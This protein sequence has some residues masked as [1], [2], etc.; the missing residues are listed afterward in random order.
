MCVKKKK[1][2][3]EIWK[4]QSEIRT[5]KE[6]ESERERVC[7]FN[8]N[9]QAKSNRAQIYVYK[10]SRPNNTNSANKKQCVSVCQ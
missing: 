6:R 5:K 10:N 8:E 1:G 2:E 9:K 3:R 7:V 4:Q